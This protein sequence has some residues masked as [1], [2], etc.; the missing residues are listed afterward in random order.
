MN[1]EHSGI[2]EMVSINHLF[3]CSVYCKQ[4][5][6]HSIYTILNIVKIIP[7]LSLSLSYLCVRRYLRKNDQ[8]IW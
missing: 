6:F 8:Q 5:C 3:E 2:L 1:L 4:T 7:S